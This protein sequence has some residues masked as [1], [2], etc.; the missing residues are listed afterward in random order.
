MI[1]IVDDLGLALH[2]LRQLLAER[3][4][5]VEGVEIHAL[6]DIAV[7]DRVGIFLFGFVALRFLGR[8]LL[9][10]LLLGGL[11]LGG[12]LRLGGVGVVIV[13]GG[14]RLGRIAG[15]AFGVLGC[16]GQG[17]QR[18]QAECGQGGDGKVP[19][20]HCPTLL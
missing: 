6:A 5:L 7:A 17:T 15:S 8:C 16:L 4:F 9:F 10:G 12:G 20:V 1:G 18:Q 3:D 13:G 2:F 11:F 14:G 19:T